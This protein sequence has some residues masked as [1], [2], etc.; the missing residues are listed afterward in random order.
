MGTQILGNTSANIAEVESTSKALRVTPKPVD[1]G[2]LGIYS[3]AA[4]SGTMAAGLAAAAPVYSFRWT[5]ATNLCVV[6]KVVISAGNTVTAFA[7]GICQFQL[8]AARSF[9][10]S[11]SAGTSILPTGNF[12]KLRTSMGTTL[13]GDVR[14]SSTAVLTVGTRTLDTN[15][16]GSITVSVPAVAG[17]TIL[18]PSALFQ[19]QDGDYPCIFAQNEGMVIQTTVPATGTWTFSVQVQWEELTSYV[20]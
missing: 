11:D 16:L 3:L 7:A 2:S 13:L 6:K 14:I 10:V 19:A 9:S 15:P 20:P 8:F 12:N 1:Y 17:T 4:P 18:G 5:H